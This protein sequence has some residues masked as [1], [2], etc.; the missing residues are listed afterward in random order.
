MSQSPVGK[1]VLAAAL[2]AA[3]L[4]W[5]PWLHWPAYPFRL[6]LTLVHELSHGVMALVTGGHFR[7]FVVFAD[8]SGLAYTAGGW[9]WAV[10]AAGYLGAA[11]FG[12]V[13]ILLGRHPRSSRWALGV[14]GVSMVLLSLRYGVPSLLT[15]HVLAGLLAL[16]TGCLLGG[17]LLWVAL[18]AGGMAT[19]FTLHLV[20]FMGAITATQDLLT[21]IGL[22]SHATVLATDARSMADL[23][24]LPAMFWAIL[25]AFFSALVMVLAARFAWRSRR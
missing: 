15:E 21:L 5:V 16:V 3:L 2:V 7:N 10:I 13:L 22:S 8:G 19:V 9:R 1:T 25:W 6:L 14:V 17:A 12:A 23:T 18:K 11:A 20:A 4:E 24:G